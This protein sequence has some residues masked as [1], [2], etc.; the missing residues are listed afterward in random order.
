MD[1]REFGE[2]AIGATAGQDGDDVDGLGDQGARNGDDGFLDE[3]LE[4]AQRAERRAGMKGADAAGMAGAPGLQQVERFRAAHLADR[5]AIGTQAKRGAH[6]IGQRATPSLVRSATRFGAVHCSSRVSSISTTRSPVL[7]TSARSALTSVVLPV[8][9]PPATRMFLRSARRGAALPHAPRDM[10]PAVDIVVEGEYRD[11]R[12]ADGEAGRRHHRRHQPFEAL[13]R[14]RAA[15][16]TRAGF[17]VDLGADMMG[18]KA[19]DPFGVGAARRAA[20]I[21]RPPDSRSIHSRPSGLSMTSTIAG[22]FEIGR[23]RPDR[24]RC[25]ACARR[26]RWLLT[27]RMRPSHRLHTT[28]STERARWGLTRKSE[29]ALSNESESVVGTWRRKT[30]TAESLRPSDRLRPTL[31]VRPRCPANFFGQG[32]APGEAPAQGFQKSVIAFTPLGLCRRLG[33]VGQRRRAGQ[34]E[35]DEQRQRFIGDRDM[36]LERSICRV[37]RSSRRAKRGFHPVGVVR[38][39]IGRKCRLDD[40]RLRHALAVGI[41]GELT[42]EI[43]RQTE[44]VL[45]AHASKVHAVAGIDARPAAP[46]WHL[47]AQALARCSLVVRLVVGE[48]ELADS[49]GLRLGHDLLVLGQFGLAP[50]AAD[51]LDRPRAGRLR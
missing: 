40:Q 29:L 14:F 6:E 7:A 23:D 32:A 20:G 27:G 51:W 45:G 44:G 3:L 26:A 34:P 10:M 46:A 33:G 35:A 22:I 28:L 11:R 38:R 21:R 48:L 19:D 39:Q 37:M 9:V 12:P 31:P 5:D 49:A 4:A 1:V 16:P 36:A 24:A 17:G 47:P 41:V 50:D 25:A 18:D 15:P 2:P 42:G 8:D 13:S 43:R 30:R